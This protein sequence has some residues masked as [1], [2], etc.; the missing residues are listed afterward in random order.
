MGVGLLLCVVLLAGCAVNPSETEGDAMAPTDFSSQ[1]NADCTEAKLSSLGG[2][3]P[4]T[5]QQYQAIQ[6]QL[7]IVRRG[8]DGLVAPV[9][10]QQDVYNLLGG[11]SSV[12]N[13]AAAAA[14][15]LGTGQTPEQAQATYVAAVATPLPAVTTAA[16]A[17]NAPA[18]GQLP[19][20]GQ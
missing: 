14:Q 18:C 9:S 10:E 12:A 8:I 7:V 16:Q 1:S 2:T 5:A 20:A 19:V 13:A 17:I 11:Y 3:A 4:Y 15:A 6:A